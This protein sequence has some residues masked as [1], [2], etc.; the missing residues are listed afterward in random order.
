MLIIRPLHDQDKQVITSLVRATIATGTTYPYNP[1]MSDVEAWELWTNPN[2]RVYVGCIG[3]KIVGTFYIR[4]NQPHL[5]AHICNAGFMVSS[6]VAGQG[7]G[8]Q[9]GT[10]ALQE[11]KALGYH[12]M[13]FNLVVATNHASIRIWEKLGF[14]TIGIVP[15]AFHHPEHGLTDALI[16]YKK[17]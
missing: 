9:L 12:A 11:A 1:N 15:E 14:S 8:T 10:Y 6:E 3:N 13:Q 7:I 16:M 5:G 17:L 2:N 4:P